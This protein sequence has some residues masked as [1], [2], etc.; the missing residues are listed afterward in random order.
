M[1]HALVIASNRGPVDFRADPNGIIS[2]HRGE[3]GLIA[4]LTPVLAGGEGVWIA[5]ARTDGDRIVARRAASTAEPTAVDLPDGVVAVRYLDL[6]PRAYA[7]YYGTI[8]TET[9]WFLHHHLPVAGPDPAWEAAW[10]DY[11][12]VNDEFAAACARAAA[13]GAAVLLQDYH[14]ALAPSQLR[15]RRPDV[16]TA[17]FTMCP[18]ADLAH[19]QRLPEQAARSL[20][21]GMLGADLLAFLTPRWARAFL[22]SCADLGYA[23]DPA[24]SEVHL[25]GRTVSVRVYPVG[26][27]VSR[28]RERTAG[29]PARAEA[30]RLDE[31]VAGRTLVARVERMEPAKNAVRGIEAFGELLRARPELVDRVVHYVLAYES[32][33]SL[34]A[35]REYAADVAAAVTAVNGRYLTAARPP[36]VLD[37]RNNLDRGLAVLARADVLVVNSWRDGMNLVA[38]E[39]AAVN[40]RDGVLI[41]SRDAGA[42]D[43]LSPYALTVDP[44]DVGQLTRA[45]ATALNL[46]SSRRRE[47]L[48]GLREASGAM[49]PR[50]WLDAV[51]ADLAALPG[52][53]GTGGADY[54]GASAGSPY[55]P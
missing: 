8:G 29:S 32:R 16:R 44:G 36:V 37:A 28:L 10:R 42:A 24:R 38:K 47:W 27:D 31:I 48:H 55:G 18:W 14:L 20:I 54:A 13:P 46:P 3:G 53:S 21:H 26:V 25:P 50:G 49:P 51:L 23:I 34:P 39:G 22:D 6:D 1:P 45:L 30:A 17:H 40:T 19:F 9:L 35:Y 15:Q 12:R 52:R 4:V 33:S 2:Y 41:L 7:A 11:E 43:E 5:G